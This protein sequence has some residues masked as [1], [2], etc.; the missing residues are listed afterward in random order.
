M[1][2]KLLFSFLLLIIFI[3]IKAQVPQKFSYQAVL[4]NNNNELVKNTQIKVKVSIGYYAYLGLPPKLTFI[5]IY[6]ETHTPQTNENGLFTLSIGGGTVLSGK[7]DTIP[8]TKYNFHLGTEIDPTGGNNYTISNITPILS[9]PYA[10]N[11]IKS[12]TAKFT[13]NGIIAYGNINSNGTVNT[14]SGNFTA[15]RYTQG[16]YYITWT[17]E[18]KINTRYDKAIVSVT[19]IANSTPAVVNFS[20]IGGGATLIVNIK[21]ASGNPMDCQ[22]S[23]F[24]INPF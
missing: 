15:S 16:T 21:D 2:T 11:S 17:S 12:D 10:L 18:S 14:G 5:S 23:F 20:S 19:P 6:S 1:K 7:F 24:V 22:F 9:V 13:K 3:V 8:W 4:R